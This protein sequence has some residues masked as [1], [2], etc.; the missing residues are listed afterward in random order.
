MASDLE[1]CIAQ[2]KVID[3]H[4]HMRF[5]DQWVDEGPTDVL[6]DLFHN[7][8]TADLA[9]AGAAPEA[10]RRVVE[11]GVDDDVEGRWAGI[12]AAWRLIETTGYGRAVATMADK[13][14][15]I[16]QITADA[17]RGA[18]A[19][20]E[21]LRRPGGRLHLLRDLAG[22]DHIQTDNGMRTV[23]PDASGPGFFFYD[24]S[25]LGFTYRGVDWELLERETDVAVKDLASLRRAFEAVFERHGPHAIAVKTQHAY[26]R[27]LKWEKRDDVDA[28]R[29][30]Q[31]MLK[32]IDE[33]DAAT[34]LC[35]GDWCL[36][37]GAELAAEYKLPLKIHT[38]TYA[39]NNTMFTDRIRAGHLCPLLQAC[40]DTRFVLMHIAYPYSEE[41]VAMA[42][43]F[44]NVWA[45][46]CWA[47]SINPRASEQFVRS[48][49]HAAPANKLF[50]FGGDTSWP[51]SAYAYALQMRQGLTRSLEAEVAEGDLTETQA[52]AFA[53][54]VLHDNQVK[55]FDLE[56]TRALNIAAAAG[57]AQRTA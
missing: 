32:S 14:Y 41:L 22:L 28:E 43:H 38:G 19:K 17:L 12:E 50:A 21:A 5:E 16:E 36:A 1:S 24:I 45:D 29:A 3:T 33:P 46:M 35:I 34:R 55:C 13:V 48:F 47:W 57:S 11:P 20:L 4:E 51:T 6:A 52:I 53:R 37:R 49:I 8:V 18:Q 31:E 15:G 9:S 56:Q 40:P 23:R 2:A 10:V 7:Y 42:K 30:L 27:T 39:G 25:W 44:P 54:R 26:L